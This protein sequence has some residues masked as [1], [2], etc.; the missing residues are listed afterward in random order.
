MNCHKTRHDIFAER[1]G[2]LGTAER[3]ALAEHLEQCPA[4]RTMRNDFT[5]T[6]EAWRASPERVTLPD[7]NLEW[8]K[9][10]REIQ[11]GTRS[12]GS[13]WRSP[14]TW[15][16]LPLAAAAALAVVLFVPSPFSPETGDRVSSVAATAG[17]SDGS[18]AAEPASTVVFVDDKT[19]WVFVWADDSPKHI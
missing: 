3:G 10:R 16:A 4:C 17:G 18:A 12:N 19:G 7:A 9:V 6:I 14:V 11:H 2:L 15:F 8:Q 13:S 5:A 1:D